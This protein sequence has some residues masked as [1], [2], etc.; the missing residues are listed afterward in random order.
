MTISVA[1]TKITSA[2][3]AKESD[4]SNIQSCLVIWNH[5]LKEHDA[6]LTKNR[7]SFNLLYDYKTVLSITETECER[8]GK[9][10]SLTV[11]LAKDTLGQIQGIG[12]FSKRTKSSYESE[13][14]EISSVI[15]APWNIHWPAEMEKKGS[16]KGGGTLIVYSIYRMALKAKTEK[17]ALSSTASAISF[18]Q[19]L[20][21]AQSSYN[22]F[23]VD[24]EKPG[25]AL[26]IT[27]CFAKTF[28]LE[29]GSSMP[30]IEG[31]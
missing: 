6:T 5:F 19:K 17:I 27:A 28:L 21:L 15:S 11:I 3:I 24:I 26:M 23:Y 14:F 4:V 2:I 30:S 9:S 20:G 10:A 29:E 1:K 18:Y 13:S 12:C 25:P 31:I 16:I 7:D 22:R 8:L